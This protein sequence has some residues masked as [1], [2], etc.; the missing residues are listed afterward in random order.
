MLQIYIQTTFSGGLSTPTLS[1]RSGNVPAG[2]NP[3]QQ[4]IVLG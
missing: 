4:P 1:P 2:L 3:V